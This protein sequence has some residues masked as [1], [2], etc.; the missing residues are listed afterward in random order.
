[1]IQRIQSVF[2]FLVA[3][4]MFG[5]L[6]TDIWVK[7]EGDDLAVLN[8]MSLTH[9][10]DDTVIAT[11]NTIYLAIVACL[12]SAI[13]MG[14]MF[15]FKN[16]MNQVKINTLNALFIAAVM[17]INV[18][19][20]FLKG[21]PMFGEEVNQGNFKAGFF[22]PIAALVFNRMATRFIWKDEKLVKSVDRLR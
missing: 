14:S 13:A 18:Y 8:A 16:R 3:A 4:C 19:L 17:G 5:V 10:N 1:M 9:S 15:S 7:I 2:L 6:F 11:V 12:A 22:L 21:I 20:V